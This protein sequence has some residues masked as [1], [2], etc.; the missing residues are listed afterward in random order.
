MNLLLFAENTTY[1][2]LAKINYWYCSSLSFL[3][4][5][6]ASLT[7]KRVPTATLFELKGSAIKV[8]PFNGK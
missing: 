4:V 8:F 3:R 6:G 1:L 2:E 5:F 7:N